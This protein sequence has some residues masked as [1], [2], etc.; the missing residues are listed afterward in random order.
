MFIVVIIDCVM[1]VWFWLV[2]IRWKCVV[3]LLVCWWNIVCICWKKLFCLFLM[4]FGYRLWL[5][6]W[7]WFMVMFIFSSRV[8]FGSRLMVWCFRLVI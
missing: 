1:L 4:W 2:L 5:L 3:L 6:V 7:V 8:N